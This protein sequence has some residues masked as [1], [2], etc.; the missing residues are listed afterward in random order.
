MEER[1]QGLL[2]ILAGC[3]GLAIAYL[4]QQFPLQP[5][6]P[7]P[8][9]PPGLVPASPMTCLLPMIGIGSV[10]L[11]LLGVKKLLFPDDWQPP[12]HMG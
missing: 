8:G 3:A 6:S 5:P 12:R 7:P 1:L 10:G 2:L 11:C 4:I 9:M